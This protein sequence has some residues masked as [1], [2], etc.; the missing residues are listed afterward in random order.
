MVKMTVVKM[1]K[2]PS[3][4]PP[5]NVT[6]SQSSFSHS[7]G[8]LQSITL[9]PSASD[10]TNGN[11]FFDDSS[12][13]NRLQAM[14]DSSVATVTYLPPTTTTPPR[15]TLSFTPSSFSVGPH[16]ITITNPD[17]QSK[18]YTNVLNIA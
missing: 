6:L 11:E 14:I 4:P 9:T 13:L 17:G 16:N 7:L 1:I 12:I 15:V 18:T 5:T 3:L 2:I 10:I 8:S